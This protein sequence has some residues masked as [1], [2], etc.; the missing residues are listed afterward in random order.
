MEKLSKF[1]KKKVISV[2]KFC[3][4]FLT[5]IML[6]TLAAD[7]SSAYSDIATKDAL[8]A[9]V[10][11]EA[12]TKLTAGERQSC[13]NWLSKGGEMSLYCKS[14]VMKLVSLDP[15][16]VTAEQRQALVYAASDCDVPPCAKAGNNTVIVE[17]NYDTGAAIIGGII[18][19][20]IGLIIANN[21][22][23]HH[24]APAPR[25]H[26][27]RPAPFVMPPKPH[28]FSRQRRRH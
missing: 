10:G 17:K 1:F 2:K 28:H 11:T 8:V 26:H 9:Y 23:H 27:F 7:T 6:L 18:G 4:A 3:I 12:F 14:A 19:I 25:P 16:A 13:L 20:G 24:Y 22:G 21:V 15:N 5:L